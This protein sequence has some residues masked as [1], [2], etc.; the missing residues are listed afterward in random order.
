M[1][2]AFRSYVLYYS[3][4]GLIL[5]PLINFNTMLV[6]GEETRE[7]LEII[8]EPGESNNTRGTDKSDIIIGNS[9]VNTIKEK[10]RTMY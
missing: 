8:P 4:L 9:I 1:N 3:L 10:M 2:T 5:S 7:N 6:M